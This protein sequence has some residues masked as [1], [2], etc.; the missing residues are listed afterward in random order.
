MLDI[1]VIRDDPEA[2]KAAMDDLNA[3]EVKPRVDAVVEL[4]VK[5]RALLTEVEALRAERK[6]V[7]KEIGRMKDNAE[8]EAK[9]AAMKESG[10]HV[11]EDLGRLGELCARVFSS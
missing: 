8:R 5:R 6:K 1:H 3:A 10:I 2:V 4:D 9:I 11:C 7:S